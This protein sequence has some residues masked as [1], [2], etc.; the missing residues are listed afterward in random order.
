MP[1]V[2]SEPQLT[3]LAYNTYASL[4]KCH[5]ACIQQYAFAIVQGSNCWCSNFAPAST[6]ATTDCN[7][8]CP[9]YPYEFCGAEDSGLFGYLALTN[10]PSGTMGSS[11][12]PTS[13]AVSLRSFLLQILVSLASSCRAPLLFLPF[14]MT[15]SGVDLCFDRHRAGHGNGQPFFFG[16]S[17]E[18]NRM[19]FP[20]PFVDEPRRRTW[21]RASVMWMNSCLILAFGTLAD[22]SR[23][24]VVVRPQRKLFLSSPIHGQCPTPRSRRYKEA[25]SP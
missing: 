1:L 20:P 22:S 23:P 2:R 13:Q 21:T 4:G 15:P 16:G 5:D 24:R 25:P 8:P 7:A 12:A 9:G 14:L 17:D 6:V 10:K 3:S 18:L 19:V 11:S